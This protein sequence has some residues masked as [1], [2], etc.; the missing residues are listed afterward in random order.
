M[1]RRIE[2]AG[3]RLAWVEEPLPPDN[4]A[5]LAAL[6][7]AVATPIAAGEHEY[8]RHGFHDLLRHNSLDIWQPDVNR[9][10]GITEA[11]KIWALGA[12]FDISVIP[13]AGQMHNYHLVIAH[14]NSPI[15]EH[16]IR[17]AH[18]IVPDEDEIFY[19]MFHGEPDAVDGCIEPRLT[20][21]KT[22]T[23]VER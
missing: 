15:A 10:S 7:E 5:C 22:R 23:L 18:R 8:T 11:L 19:N 21:A 13:Y 6:R 17:P 14:M 2:D 12:N 4:P 9:A 20:R 3:H 1:I 16:F